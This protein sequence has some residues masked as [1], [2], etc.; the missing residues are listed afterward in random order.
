MILYSRKLY[1]IFKDDSVDE[2]QMSRSDEQIRRAHEHMSRYRTSKWA[3]QTIRLGT[4]WWTR[5]WVHSI[6][7]TRCRRGRIG[8]IPK[9]GT[10]LTNPRKKR[11][12]PKFSETEHLLQI[13][14]PQFFIDTLTSLTKRLYVW[15][16]M[17]G[18]DV[19]HA[20]L[21][22]KSAQIRIW[23]TVWTC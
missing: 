20:L 4:R 23:R 15:I 3:D 13:Y 5:E 18:I 11:N 19:T 8:T 21:W 22:S 12:S 2:E 14:T 10:P 9:S 7:K 6:I 16:H 17:D 1:R